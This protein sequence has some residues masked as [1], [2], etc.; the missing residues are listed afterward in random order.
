M[1]IRTSIGRSWR[2]PT[3][4][5]QSSTSA[6]RRSPGGG[7]TNRDSAISQSSGPMYTWLV[8]MR[9]GSRTG[10]REPSA[11]IFCMS[12]SKPTVTGRSR[13]HTNAE[14]AISIDLTHFRGRGL[15]AGQLCLHDLTQGPVGALERRGS[16]RLLDQG[17]LDQKA[18]VGQ[19]GARLPKC[20]DCIGCVRCDL[21]RLVAQLKLVGQRKRQERLVLDW[22]P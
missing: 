11:R 18:G 17:R 16:L 8:R 10:L 2:A 21:P 1:A 14:R 3:H 22:L 7:G 5:R 20:P 15:E 13:I 19:V 6:R 12:Q 4:V 9:P